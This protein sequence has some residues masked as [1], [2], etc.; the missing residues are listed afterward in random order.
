MLA[1]TTVAFKNILSARAEW[2]ESAVVIRHAYEG[3]PPVAAT[4][5]ER[6][7]TQKGGH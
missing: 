3:L 5:R 6:F 4:S 7:L 1:V 2:S